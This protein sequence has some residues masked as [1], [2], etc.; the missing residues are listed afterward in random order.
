MHWI[1]MGHYKMVIL[2]PWMVLVNDLDI[3]DNLDIAYCNDAHGMMIL[4]LMLMAMVLKVMLA[5]AL[6]FLTLPALD[7]LLV[8]L[9][10]VQKGG[11]SKPCSKNFGG[12]FV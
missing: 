4:V 7:E 8:F 9:N 6:I 1:A 2:V 12:N 5:M 3:G 11:R 10:I